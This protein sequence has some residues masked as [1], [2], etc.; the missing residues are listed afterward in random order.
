MK[1]KAIVDGFIAVP[2]YTHIDLPD[3]EEDDLTGSACPYAAKSEN[4]RAKLDSSYNKHMYLLEDLREP[5][6]KIFKL[7]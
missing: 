3:I 4:Q 5:I 2:V 7:D 1:E 6:T